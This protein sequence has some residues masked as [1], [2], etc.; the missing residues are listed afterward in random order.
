MPKFSNTILELLKDKSER[1]AFIKSLSAKVISS[2]LK[3]LRKNA[4]WTQKDLA[5][6]SRKPQSVISRLEDAD[7]G[8]MTLKTLYE[9]CEAF[10]VALHIRFVSFSDYCRLNRDLSWGAMT[11]KAFHDDDLSYVALY[12]PSSLQGRLPEPNSDVKSG[13]LD[14]PQAKIVEMLPPEPGTNDSWTG[15]AKHGT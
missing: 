3:Q 15:L 8:K 12:G 6:N 4:G 5:K 7:Y 13:R 14:R 10:D 1:H 2:Q 11:A 9:M